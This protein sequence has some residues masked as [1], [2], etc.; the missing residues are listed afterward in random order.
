[1]LAAA[2]KDDDEVRVTPFEAVGFSL[3]ALWP[4]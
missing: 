1:V 2:L 3:A 4:D